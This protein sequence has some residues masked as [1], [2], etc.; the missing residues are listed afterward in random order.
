[1]LQNLELG[2]YFVQS[3]LLDFLSAHS[4]TLE[5]RQRNWTISRS[6]YCYTRLM[7]LIAPQIFLLLLQ[8]YD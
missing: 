1:M 2:Y 7:T 8:Q 4:S 6:R 5:V 3:D